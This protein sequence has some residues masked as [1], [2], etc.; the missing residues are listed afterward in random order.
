MPDYET[1]L[2]EMIGSKQTVGSVGCIQDGVEGWEH[3]Q[4][5]VL[6]GVVQAQG[7]DLLGRHCHLNP[8]RTQ[9]SCHLERQSG[10]GALGRQRKS[11]GLPDTSANWQ[12]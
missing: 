7:G 6:E 11:L 3:G 5:Q 2:E 10:R 4:G 1:W 12:T 8:S 9:R